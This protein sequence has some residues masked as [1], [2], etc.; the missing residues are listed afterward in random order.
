MKKK[1]FLPLISACL[2]FTI[3]CEK[4]TDRLDNYLVNFAT[5]LREGPAYRFQLDNQEILIPKDAKNYTGESGQRVVLN[6]V[7]LT[8]DTIQINWISDIFTGTVLSEGFPERLSQDPVKIQSVWVGGSYLNMILEVEYHSRP[9]TIA[10]LRDTSSP[11]I[12]LYLSHSREND[13]PGYP[14]IMYASFLLNDLRSD[15]DSTPL[16]F[17]LFVNTYDGVRE[18]S[19][20]L[21]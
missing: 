11:Y 21:K 5:V 15:G 4:E 3:G 9:H 14:K 10:L 1:I 17:R 19:L 18:F 6:Y 8:G 13:P 12:D 16:P 2:L 20:E 7:P